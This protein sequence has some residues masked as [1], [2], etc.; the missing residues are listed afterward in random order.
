MVAWMNRI[1]QGTI[2]AAALQ[3]CQTPYAIPE[4]AEAFLTIG[5]TETVG[6]RYGGCSHSVIG[7]KGAP[8]QTALEASGPGNSWLRA[9]P[10]WRTLALA[11][12]SAMWERQE[13]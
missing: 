7:V 9:A 10:D 3:G 1:P 5:A 8:M 12:D 13:K 6:P 11:V 2:V 4:V